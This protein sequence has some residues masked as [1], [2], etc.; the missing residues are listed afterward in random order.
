MEDITYKMIKFTKTSEQIKLKNYRV[1]KN[2]F[3]TKY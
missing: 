3:Y 2:K 1:M